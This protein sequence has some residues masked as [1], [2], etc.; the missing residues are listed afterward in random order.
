MKQAVFGKTNKIRED[1]TKEVR[2]VVRFHPKL[3]SLAKNIKELSKYLY[4]DF[5]VMTVF[6]HTPMVSFRK[7]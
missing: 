6:T 3:T 4:I 1:S 2:F 7:T 5:E